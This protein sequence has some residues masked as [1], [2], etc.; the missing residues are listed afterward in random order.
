[1]SLRNIPRKQ[2]LPP[3]PPSAQLVYRCRVCGWTNYGWCL[4]AD[5]R[6]VVG[7]CLGCAETRGAKLPPVREVMW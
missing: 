4:L 7:L 2:Y 5:P 3:L 1:M 6:I